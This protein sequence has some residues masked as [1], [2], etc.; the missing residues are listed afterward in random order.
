MPYSFGKEKDKGEK[1]TFYEIS[2]H[3]YQNKMYNILESRRIHVSK[4]QLVKR[5][6]YIDEFQIVHAQT[7]S[8]CTTVYTIY[9]KV[10]L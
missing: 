5:Q 6:I 4:I 3:N 10:G 1:K 9:D 8:T 7:L 2:H